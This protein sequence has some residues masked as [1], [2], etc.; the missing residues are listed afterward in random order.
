MIL[1]GNFKPN[2]T[3]GLNS[4][5]VNQLDYFKNLKQEDCN[6]LGWK[7]SFPTFVMDVKSRNHDFE[8]A[9]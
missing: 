2:L 9:V 8:E 7:N 5:V 1:R 4:K 6:A 3:I